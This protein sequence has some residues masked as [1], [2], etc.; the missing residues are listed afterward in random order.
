MDTTVHF[1]SK[2]VEHAT[3]R[4][5]FA[6]L[7]AEF[8]FTL[9]VCATAQNACLDRYLDAEIDGLTYDWTGEV[10]WMNP[11]Y[12]RT[13]G[14]WVAKAARSGTRVVCLLPARTDTRWWHDFIWD[15]TTNAPRPG[16]Q[17]RLIRGRLRFGNAKSGAP[18]PSAVVI[19]R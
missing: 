7:H 18:F 17:L 5:F 15:E 14:A 10:C 6:E 1:S 12:G 2:T 13:I 9:D 3:P 19:F 11:P 16:V 4:D 8:H